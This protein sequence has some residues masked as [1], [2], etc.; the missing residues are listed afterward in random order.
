MFAII[1]G[2]SGL[3]ICYQKAHE[4]FGISPHIGNALLVLDT[5]LFLV[6]GTLYMKKIICFFNEVK[7]EYY[8][9]VR[10]NFFA[11]ISISI[12]LLSIAYKEIS[13]DVSYTLFIIGSLL[14]LFLTFRTIGYWI[15]N[16]LEITHSNPAWFIPIVGNILVPVA[17][18]DFA[19]SFVLMFYFSIGLFFWFVLFTIVFYRIIFHH[20]MAQKF[21]PTL[22]IF[23]APPAVGF[24]AYIKMGF[25]M[26]T[27]ATLLLCIA[28]FF[29]C[30]L[31]FLYKNFIYMK[32]FISWW[33][34]TF[35]MAAITIA[36]MLASHLSGEVVLLYLSCVFLILTTL[37]ISYVGARTL[38]HIYKREICVSEH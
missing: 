15:E 6:I 3:T 17:G 4:F 16:N 1:M 10:I 12:L 5:A 25:T 24:I 31:F 35:P 11:A 32:Y 19:Y 38:E 2:V 37:I 33:A 30:L 21:M 27:F 26:D 8:H 9:P 20:Q 22:F 29:T 23:I 7:S 34:F 14:H 36:T 18:A 28:I 13:I